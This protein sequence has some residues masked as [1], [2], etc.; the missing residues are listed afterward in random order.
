MSP[1]KLRTVVIAVVGLSALAVTG[2]AQGGTAKR[3]INATVTVTITDRTLQATP[4]NPESGA[5]RFVV[6]NKG[7]KRHFFTISGPGVKSAKTGKIPPGKSATLT[8]TLKP[9][10]YVLSD[11]IGL[12]TYTSAFLSV[13]RNSS[14]SGH[15]NSNK[16][17]PEIEPPPMCGEYFTP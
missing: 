17:Q 9:G 10:A 12:G 2:L 11:P 14:L 1:A 7:K 5:T 16:V 15:G 13:I 4:L 6:L 8:V 3:T